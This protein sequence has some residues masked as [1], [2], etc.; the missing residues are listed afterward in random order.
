MKPLVVLLLVLGALAA[1]L[2]A[3]T[4]LTDSSG[5]NGPEK[6]GIEA[7][8]TATQE[9]PAQLTG[10]ATPID[11]PVAARQEPQETRQAAQGDEPAGRK[12]AFGAIE[13]IVVDKKDD[14]PIADATVNLLNTKPSTLGDD[15][16]VLRGED[17][18]RPVA[19][20]VTDATGAFRFDQLD[21][22]K[23]WSFV[24]THERYLT[25]TPD[26]AIRVPEGGVWNEQV[27]MEEGQTLQGVVKDAHS[28]QP[29]PGAHLLVDGSFS[30]QNRKKSASC[31]EATTDANGG[32]VFKNVGAAFGQGR[33][34]SVS[35]PGYA[36]QVHHNIVLAAISDAPIKFKNVQSEPSLIGR[37]QDFELEPGKVIAGKVF[38]VEH[39]GVPGVEIEALSQ[40]GTIACTGVT[41]SS[42]K[43]EFLIEGLAEGLY[44]VRITPA[45]YDASPLQRVE[46]GDTNVEI[47][48]FELGTVTGRVVDSNGQPLTSF[49]VKARTANEVS[50][51]YGAVTAQRA[52]KSANDGRFELKG[53]PE[54]AYVIEGLAQGF[55]SSFS[56]TFNVTQGIITSDIVVR[57]TRGGSLSGRVV[58]SYD[59]APVAGAEISTVDNDYIDG[60]IWELFGALE[61]S[62]T[63]KTKVYTDADGRFSIEVMTPDV[64]QVQIS[65]LGYS[66][67]AVK[68]VQVVEGQMNEMPPLTLIKGAVIRGIVYGPGKAPQPGAS[69]QLTPGDYGFEGHRTARTD[70]AG[71]FVIENARP[72]TYQLS[73]TRPASGQGNPFEAIADMKQS[74]VEVSIED[75][76]AYDF[77]LQ[78]GN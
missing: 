48:L 75:G 71:R 13:G 33:T 10:A 20:V 60:Q 25:N 8:R 15:V 34:L 26:T 74:Q 7:S 58:N 52:V 6:G 1:L 21:P 69:V 39:R 55:A 28:H 18:P 14:R 77:D 23:D 5:R 61:P 44:T 38:D 67:L 42:G 45:H 50:K 76:K 63:T 46:A 51:A 27:Q 16:N 62:A 17:P 57:M 72:G 9:P 30:F 40:S 22:R 68:D 4:S 65:A 70:A 66:P 31:I 53:V 78:L 59:A 73:A 47:E 19:K 49:V 41:K 54:G 37:E 64:Y 29:I 56:D 12:V 36:T 11:A 2:F 35:A 32:Y 43:G 3:L 24:V